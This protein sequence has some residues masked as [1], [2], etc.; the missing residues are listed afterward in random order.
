M[1][2]WADK[3]LGRQAGRWM[4]GLVDDCMFGWMNR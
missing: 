1:N 2:E 3:G 4:D